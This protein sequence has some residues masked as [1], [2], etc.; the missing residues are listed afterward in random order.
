MSKTLDKL[1][2]AHPDKIIGW[3]HDSDGY[4]V[5]LKTGWQQWGVHTVH[6]D[7]VKDTLAFGVPLSFEPKR[8]LSPFLNGIGRDSPSLT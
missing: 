2:A 6:E 4:W 7:S 1:A 3:Y 8:T 5:E